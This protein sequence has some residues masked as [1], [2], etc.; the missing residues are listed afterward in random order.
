MEQGEGLKMAYHCRLES[1]QALSRIPPESALAKYLLHGANTLKGTA[2]CIMSALVAS[3]NL[4]LSSAF[5]PS[6]Q[7]T[8]GLREC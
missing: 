2:I 1:P 7:P 5:L 6:Y 3:V 8:V 4:H